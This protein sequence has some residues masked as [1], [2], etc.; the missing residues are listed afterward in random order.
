MFVPEKI[1]TLSSPIVLGKDDAAI[2]YNELKLREP[3]AG[4][5]EKAAAAGTSVGQTINLISL[6]AKVPRGVA[7]RMSQRDFLEAGDFFGSFY[8]AGEKTEEAG[9]S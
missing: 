9:Q 1:L 3:T 6:V 8:S 4:E 2:T 7:E 5:L